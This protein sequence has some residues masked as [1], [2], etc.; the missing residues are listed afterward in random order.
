[1]KKEEGR[2]RRRRRRRGGGGGRR[3]RRRR[4]RRR[5]R[6]RIIIQVVRGPRGPHKEDGQK[7][8][9]N[10]LRPLLCEDRNLRHPHITEAAV[11]R[12]TFPGEGNK[13]NNWKRPGKVYICRK[14]L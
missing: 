5:R 14:S 7:C 12:S 3:G 13:S 11:P 1:M 6:R 4:K 9:L 8:E 2:R 10:L